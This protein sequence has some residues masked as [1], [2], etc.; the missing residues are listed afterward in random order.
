MDIG[1]HRMFL[2]PCEIHVLS[3]VQSQNRLLLE[4][5]RSPEADQLGIVVSWLPARSQ[6]KYTWV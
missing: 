2:P 5:E 6:R 4:L 3:P 1:E